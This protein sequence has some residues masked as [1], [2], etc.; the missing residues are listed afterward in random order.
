MSCVDKPVGASYVYRVST[1]VSGSR[2]PSAR[3]RTLRRAAA[4]YADGAQRLVEARTR[5]F[6]FPFESSRQIQVGIYI[7]FCV[8]QYNIK[9]SV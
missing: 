2:V 7:E 6:P 5:S 3:E 8:H 9:S 1:F 4:P